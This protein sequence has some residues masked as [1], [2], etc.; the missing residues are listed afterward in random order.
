MKAIA[1]VMAV[2]WC[3][4]LA[5]Q[6]TPTPKP[7]L[8]TWRHVGPEVY[9][10]VLASVFAPPANSKDTRFV[11]KLRFLPS[12]HPE[13]EVIVD[14]SLRSRGT[15]TVRTA[16]EIVS[17]AIDEYFTRTGVKDPATLASSVS[18]RRVDRDLP[19]GKTAAWVH[20]FWTALAES[21]PL[22]DRKSL[23]HDGTDMITI[24]LDGTEYRLEYEDSMHKI[25]LVFRGSAVGFNDANDS[26]DLPIVRW[27]NAVRLEAQRLVSQL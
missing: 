20:A 17:D 16:K 15:I 8:T 4:Q 27:M 9:E 14:H 13:S 5:A 1:C 25:S 6:P 3:S 7:Q 12:F 11:M 10:Q 24:Q 18:M 2:L 19:V 22:L 21:V 26:G 23:E